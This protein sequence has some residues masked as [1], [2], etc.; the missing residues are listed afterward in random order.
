MGASGVSS[1]RRGLFLDLDGT[2]ADSLGALKKAYA[3]FLSSHGI[4]GCDKEFESLN[5]PSLP[6]IVRR[7]KVDHGLVPSERELLDQY[8][9]LLMDSHGSTR[10]NSGAA[11]LLV[12]ARENGWIVG[13]VTSSPRS[14][15]TRWLRSNDFEAQFDLLVCGDDVLAAKPAPDAYRLATQAAQV[16]PLN[17]IAIEDSK[18]GVTAAAAA[19]LETWRLVLTP[20]TRGYESRQI[21]SLHE[22]AVLL[23][24][25]D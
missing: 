7:L 10:A 25:C 1:R 24:A 4:A 22:A 16:E 8:R 20:Q 2:L 19:G 23:H 18:A 5:G 11:E 9:E 21:S 17:S 6:E 12:S 14:F 13:L 15:A 3:V